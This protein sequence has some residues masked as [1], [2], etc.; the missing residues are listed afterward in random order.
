[1]LNSVGILL[2]FSTQIGLRKAVMRA[3]LY[4]VYRSPLLWHSLISQEGLRPFPERRDQ[5]LIKAAD[6]L[7]NDLLRR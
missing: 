1:M 2:D 7:Q 6:D 3:S 4:L 5:R